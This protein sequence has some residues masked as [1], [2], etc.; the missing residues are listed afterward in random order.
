MFLT[1]IAEFWQSISDGLNQL[2]ENIGDWNWESIVTYIKNVGI[3][4]FLTVVL[5]TG[6]PVFKSLKN[7]N[8]PILK[9]VGRLIERIDSLEKE[10][11]TV[12]NV[13]TEYI[14]LQSETNSMS[15]TLPQEQKDKFLAFATTLKE[16][17]NARLQSIG[18][19]IEKMVED[20]EITA[21]EA[22]ELLDTIPEAKKILGTNIND[23]LPKV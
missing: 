14:A 22:K 17:Q 23:I 13:L 10:N 5:K 2:F 3:M 15:I 18:A 6:L 9:L 8:K 1:S 21:D 4:G 11:Q 19:D 7:S 20:N 16:M 12:G